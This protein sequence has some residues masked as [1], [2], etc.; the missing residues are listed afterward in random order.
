MTEDDF[1]EAVEGSLLRALRYMRTKSPEQT[2]T[3]D[4]VE[5]VT[6]Q[7]LRQAQAR[8][9]SKARVERVLCDVSDGTMHCV[10]SVPAH[11]ASLLDMEYE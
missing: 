11:L 7:V 8:C 2:M 9:G 4:S 3:R 1:K 5:A 6:A 10:I